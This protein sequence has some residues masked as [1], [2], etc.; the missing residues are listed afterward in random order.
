MLKT[1]TSLFSKR[2]KII[3]DELDMK[4]KID[5]NLPLLIGE[6]ILK[7]ADIKYKLSYTINKGVIKIETDNKL[8]A[9]EI[10]IRIRWLEE[11]LKKQGVVFK[12]L[13]I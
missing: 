9:Q 6:E 7:R 13:L 10:A 12:K 2:R 3:E 1:I 11:R 8:V 4:S 5:K